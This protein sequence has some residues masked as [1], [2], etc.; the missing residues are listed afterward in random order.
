M[1]LEARSFNTNLFHSHAAE[2]SPVLLHT[3]TASVSCSPPRGTPSGLMPSSFYCVSHFILSK[4]LRVRIRLFWRLH[5][6]FTLV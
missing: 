4:E 6:L 1:I 2:V 5:S 3:F